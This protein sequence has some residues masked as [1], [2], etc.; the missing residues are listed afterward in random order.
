M[1]V[2][3]NKDVEN[4]EIYFLEY[5]KCTYKNLGICIF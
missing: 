4:L 3:N 1:K 2:F 5:F